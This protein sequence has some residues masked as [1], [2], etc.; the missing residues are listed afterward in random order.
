MAGA[1]G[2][3]EVVNHLHPAGCHQRGPGIT[4]VVIASIV[5]QDDFLGAGRIRAFG[6]QH[7]RSAWFRST[8]G[9]VWRKVGPVFQRTEVP[10]LAAVNEAFRHGLEL[11]PAGADGLG[12]GGADVIVTGGIGDDGEEVGKF[13]DDF[14]GRRDEVV[15]VG[16]VTFGILDE[17]AATA[18]ADP[19]DDAQV[20][21]RTE[22]RI[23]AVER[24]GGA[25]AGGFVRRFRP[26]VDH[27]QGKIQVG[28]N[29]LGARALQDFAQNFM[30]MHGGKMRRGPEVG[31]R[32]GGGD[33]QRSDMPQRNKSAELSVQAQA[34][35]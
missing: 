20:I 17:E 32:E 3:V 22:Q 18:L 4:Q 34:Y 33:L 1:V 28:G 19:V 24:I 26:F 6:I 10:L 9:R 29:L 25:A 7:A 31:K 13:L 21:G 2:A 12:F 14:V 30:G 5:P 15:G 35:R 23:N 16:R 11:L 8:L 27:G